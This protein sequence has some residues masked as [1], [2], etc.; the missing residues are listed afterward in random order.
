MIALASL[1]EVWVVLAMVVGAVM[2]VA[3]CCP[4]GS[5]R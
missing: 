2:L 1:P 5:K 4:K 3:V